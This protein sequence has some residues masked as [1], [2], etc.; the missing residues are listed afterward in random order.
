ME[1]VEAQNLLDCK[2]LLQLCV[3]NRGSVPPSSR[4]AAMKS[5]MAALEV[6][7]TIDRRWHTK[8]AYDRRMMLGT[9]AVIGSSTSLDIQNARAQ[10]YREVNRSVGHFVSPIALLQW[11]IERRDTQR[12]LDLE[13]F[14]RDFNPM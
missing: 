13:L 5:L 6:E 12:A 10:A 11:G 7:R 3:T 2:S 1:F 14:F 9:L 4:H 8:F